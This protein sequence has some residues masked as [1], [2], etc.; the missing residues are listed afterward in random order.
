[1]KY[2]RAA[3]A[4]AL[5]NNSNDQY[6]ELNADAISA[7]YQNVCLFGGE[8]FT[9]SFKHAGRNLNTAESLKFH[10]GTITGS[11]I[12]SLQ[13]I[14]SDTV[15][16]TSSQTTISTRW[17]SVSVGNTAETVGG[18]NSYDRVVCILLVFEATNGSTEGNFLDDIIIGLK[19]AVEFSASSNKYYEGNDNISG[20]TQAVPFI[21]L[22]ADF[23][24]FRYAYA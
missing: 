24:C 2:G 8:Q 1:M 15:T 3:G 16:R 21:L 5:P 17:K 12:S 7:L 9:W 6:A 13:T 19:P 20:K 22:G 4:A 23:K 14:V 11:S 10:I 18:G